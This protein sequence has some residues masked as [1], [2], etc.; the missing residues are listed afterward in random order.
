LKQALTDVLKERWKY[1]KSETNSS[2]DDPEA[3]FQ[4]WKSFVQEL[5]DSTLHQLREGRDDWGASRC[6]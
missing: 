4:H 6:A 2:Y 1:Q 3:L 5:C